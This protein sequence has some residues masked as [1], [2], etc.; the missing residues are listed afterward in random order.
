MAEPTATNI[1]KITSFCTQNSLEHFS[2][3]NERETADL[4]TPLFRVNA[5][6]WFSTEA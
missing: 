5:L 3:K 2:A 6:S 4:S 1:R